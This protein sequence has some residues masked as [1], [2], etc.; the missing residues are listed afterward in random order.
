[1]KKISTAALTLVLPLL[2][3]SAFLVGVPQTEAATTDPACTLYIIHNNQVSE[4]K[5]QIN[6]QVAKNDFVG[7]IWYGMNVTSA[8]DTDAKTVP[9]LGAQIILPTRDKSYS[10]TF[11]N[12][13]KNVTCNIDIEVISGSVSTK[14]TAKSDE[15]F[16]LTGKVEGATKA[17]IA[18]Y[19]P[20]A[21]TPIY[22]TKAVTLKREKFSFKM[23]KALVDDTYHIVLQTTDAKPIVLATSTITVGKPKPV[24][25]TTLVV[26]TVPLLSGGVVKVGRGV[27]VAYLQVIN[28][29]TTPAQLT[30]FTFGQVGT[31]PTTAIVGVSINDE[32]GLS[33]GSVGNMVS[34]T[35]FTGNKVV[36]PVPVTLAAKESRLFTVRAVVGANAT[37]N[38]GQ[39]MLLSLQSITGNAKIQSSLPVNGVTWTIGQ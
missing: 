21:T 11:S 6:I 25:Q 20:G 19:A 38:I 34:G 36:I 1:M 32:L 12:G 23:P 15:K 27:A 9:T 29:G 16:T 2:A 22:T 10:Y 7:L 3:L 37:A 39:T 18:F 17:V 4:T 24:A 33:K 13:V 28:V 26:Q 14:S 30:D 35:P 8:V 31:A 5:S